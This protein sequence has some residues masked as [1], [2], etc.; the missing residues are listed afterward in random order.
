MVHVSSLMALKNTVMKQFLTLL[1]CGSALFTRAQITHELHVV[2]NVFSPSTMQIHVGDAVR[3]I[4]DDFDHSFTQ[5]SGATWNVN[6]DTPL[7]GGIN[8]GFG[9]P[10]PGVDTTITFNEEGIFYYVCIHHVSMGMKGSI[11]ISGSADVEEATMQG[12]WRLA[13]NPANDNARLMNAK[14]I[15]V[16]VRVFDST[17]QQALAASTHGD[18]LIFVGDL[19][20]GQYIMEIRDPQLNLLSRERLMVQREL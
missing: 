10:S 4:F 15:P 19:P 11:S 2:D 5:V 1:L 17:G 13:P 6:G 14:N 16:I 12:L 9:T 3:V 18:N 8:Y 7:P 20:S